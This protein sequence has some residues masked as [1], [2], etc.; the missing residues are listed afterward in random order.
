MYLLQ[1]RR[2]SQFFNWPRNMYFTCVY[3]GDGMKMS[4]FPIMN[5]IQ[6]DLAMEAAPFVANRSHD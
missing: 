3:A 1:M 4:W 5:A 2:K 6:K